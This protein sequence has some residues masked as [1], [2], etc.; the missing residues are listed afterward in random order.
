MDREHVVLV[1]GASQAGKSSLC[2]AFVQHNGLLPYSPTIEVKTPSRTE[3]NNPT[4][5]ASSP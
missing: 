5:L 3:I 1:L 4:F 2:T